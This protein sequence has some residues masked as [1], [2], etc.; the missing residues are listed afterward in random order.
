MVSLITSFVSELLFPT[1]DRPGSSEANPMHVMAVPGLMTLL[2]VALFRT[3]EGQ[4]TATLTTSHAL[5]AAWLSL[6]RQAALVLKELQQQQD[7]KPGYQPPQRQTQAVQMES[8]ARAC[9]EA[10]CD[11]IQL[12]NTD[13]LTSS[14]NLSDPYDSSSAPSDSHHHHRGSVL[15]SASSS[16]ELLAALQESQLDTARRRYPLHQRRR[17]CWESPRLY[18]P[19]HVWAD[20]VWQACQ[21][22]LRQLHKHPLA[23]ELHNR[24]L[25]KMEASLSSPTSPSSSF[26]RGGNM[27]AFTE[28]SRD[29]LVPEQMHLLWLVLQTD[30][31]TRLFQFRAA[32]EA[33]SVVTKRLYLIKCE[34]RAPFRAFLEAHHSVQR[35]PSL[36]LVQEF[37][38]LTLPAAASNTTTSSSSSSNKSSSIKNN[39]NKKLDQ[40][41]AQV[42][43]RLSA[44]LETPQLVEALALEQR[45]EEYESGMAQALFSFGELARYLDQ[46]H[47][48]VV[49]HAVPGILPTQKVG[50]VQELLGRLSGLLY[51]RAGTTNASAGIRPLLLDLQGVWRDEEAVLK[52][53]AAVP[54][55][56]NDDD[57]GGLDA[58]AAAR[59]VQELLSDLQTLGALCRT[60][61]AFWV[62]EH[63]RKVEYLDIPSSIVRGCTDLDTELFT[64]QFTDWCTMVVRQNELT[65]TKDFAGLAEK[66]RRAEMQM[67][68]AVASHKSLEV[69][70]QR[71]EALAVDRET[72]FQV[73]KAMLEEVCLREMNLHVTVEAP[74]RDKILPLPKTSALGVFGKALEL[75]GEPL[76]IG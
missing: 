64:C 25:R 50:P 76:P 12:I 15:T 42:Q 28:H 49:H 18:C 55:H 54:S 65:R 60:R 24:H 72:R 58:A 17:D 39:N 56:G 13:R 19:D 68:L 74:E 11:A 14:A 6:Q 9:F 57:Q 69:V 61:H 44:L 67:S 47:A 20:D 2:D 31:P 22:L 37:S 52:M 33:E 3:V 46:K 5:L 63:D 73:A 7:G 29:H 36:G 16:E 23:V 4:L 32:M 10:A 43:D 8:L 45:C 59:R 26:S 21:R 71:L 53:R 66:L 30:L 27:T 35:A 41:R 62:V 1:P 38:D 40:R 48:R 51:R 75:A 34:Y 70:R